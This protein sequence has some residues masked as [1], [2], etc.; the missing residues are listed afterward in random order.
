MTQRGSTAG[1]ITPRELAARGYDAANLE[2]GLQAWADTGLPL[3]TPDGADGK[4]G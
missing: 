1:S 3:R 2:C 4:V